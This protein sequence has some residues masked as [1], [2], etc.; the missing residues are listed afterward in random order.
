MAVPLLLPLWDYV[1]ANG[2]PYAGGTVAT[3]VPGTTT[4]ADT[5]TDETE[6]ALNPNPVVLDSAGRAAIYGSGEYRV[7]LRDADGN[8][9]F[10]RNTT[11][12]VSD[13]MA[14]VVDAPTIADALQLLG[15]QDLI[16]AAVAAETTRAEAAEQALQTALNN[17]ISRAE[18]AESNL[19]SSINHLQSEIDAINAQLA[20]EATAT[21]WVQTYTRA[22]ASTSLSITV[23]A[24][25]KVQVTWSVNPGYNDYVQTPP[26]PTVRFYATGELRCDGVLIG[27]CGYNSTSSP[28]VLGRTAPN[29]MANMQPLTTVL[30]VAQPNTWGIEMPYPLIGIDD[31]GSGSHTYVCTFYIHPDVVADSGWTDWPGNFGAMAHCWLLLELV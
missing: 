1:D 14:P 30:P 16:N 27:I 29:A 20:A 9:I 6:S 3:F 18:A 23:P 13:A 12:I 22:Q 21:T 26:N 19:Q 25:N 10:D 28:L 11:T 15:I 5:W 2:L 4:P 31:P 7:I 17:E 24:G 8:L